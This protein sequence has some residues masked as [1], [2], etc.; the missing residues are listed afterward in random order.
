MATK[1]K[2]DSEKL[3]LLLASVSELK[4]SQDNMKKMF[5]SKLDKM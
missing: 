1:K 2:S 3:D 4:T 5:E